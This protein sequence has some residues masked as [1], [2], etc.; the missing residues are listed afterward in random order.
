MSE[1]RVPSRGGAEGPPSGV[2]PR[3]DWEEGMIPWG[4][5]EIE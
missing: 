3:D 4:E 2:V 1:H 5:T